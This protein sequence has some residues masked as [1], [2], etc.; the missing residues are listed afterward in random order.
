MVSDMKV[1]GTSSVFSQHTRGMHCSKIETAAYERR[2]DMIR[3]S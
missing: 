1:S 3:M 2:S